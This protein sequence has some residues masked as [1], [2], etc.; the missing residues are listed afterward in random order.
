MEKDCFYCDGTGYHFGA[1]CG[2]C[3]GVGTEKARRDVQRGYN[4]REGLGKHYN[5]GSIN[6]GAD[7]D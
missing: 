1:K 2:A 5:V 6:G 4:K 3:K 7:I